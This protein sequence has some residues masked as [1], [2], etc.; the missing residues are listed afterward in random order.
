MLEHATPLKRCCLKV[1][2]LEGI[3]VLL[4]YYLYY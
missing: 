2:L 4:K 1:L 3:P